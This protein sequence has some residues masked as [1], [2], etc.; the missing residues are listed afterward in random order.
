MKPLRCGYGSGTRVMPDR[1]N[2]LRVLLVSPCSRSCIRC[3][4]L[5]HVCQQMC[6]SN[7]L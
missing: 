5:H 7:T 1:P 6:C 2:V 4:F 3:V